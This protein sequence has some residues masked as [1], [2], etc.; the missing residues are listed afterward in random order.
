[1]GNSAEWVGLEFQFHNT[2]PHW[3]PAFS[4]LDTTLLTIFSTW[5]IKQ[6]LCQCS[7]MSSNKASKNLQ[8]HFHD[9]Y[10][11]YSLPHFFH[12]SEQHCIIHLGVVCLKKKKKRRRLYSTQ[13]INSQKCYYIIILYTCLQLYTCLSRGSIFFWGRS[14]LQH[15]W[16]ACPQLLH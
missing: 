10:V 16:C 11:L 2:N 4:T 9:R 8:F 3:Q 12:L 14:S 1:M 13:S 15:R 7:T 6:F 5:M